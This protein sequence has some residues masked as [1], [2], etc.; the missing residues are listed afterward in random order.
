MGCDV[1]I[2]VVVR[3]YLNLAFAPS[4]LLPD[5]LIDWGHDASFKEK[6]A[7]GS[8]QQLFTEGGRS[9]RCRASN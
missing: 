3:L 5:F 9:E 2:R 6:A 7:N 4:R 8:L 1:R